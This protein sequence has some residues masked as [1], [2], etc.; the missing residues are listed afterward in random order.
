[1]PAR[2]RPEFFPSLPKQP[3]AAKRWML[4]AVLAA[5]LVVV[6]FALRRVHFEWGIFLTQLRHA[7]VLYLLLGVVCIYIGYL[8][9]A[10]R[11]S[12]FLRPQKPFPVTKLVGTQVI[13][14]TAVALFGRLADPVRPL[15]V[16]RRVGVTVSS[17]LAVYAMDRM[18]DALAM[19]L[20]FSSALALAPDARTLPHHELFQHA[21]YAGLAIAIAGG[22]FA[23]LIRVRGVQIA[24]VAA[25]VFGRISAGAGEAV[26]EKILAFRDG[27]RVLRSFGDFVQALAVSL[28][29]W[30][31]ILVAYFFTV[32]AF[33]ELRFFNLSRIMLLSAASLG[34][35]ALQLPV[36]GWFTQIGIVSAAMKGLGAPLE[37]AIG[38]AAMLLVVTFLSVIP[39]GLV[40]AKAEGVNLREVTRQS[41]AV[42]E[43]ALLG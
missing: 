25:R 37:P 30:A 33:A 15:L 9:R 5:L 16:S 27:M 29:M 34:G 32:H 6:A 18:F 3:A 13:G 14:F 38:A 8:C 11:W 41:E 28:L 23:V 24:A 39:A 4:W 19:A 1:M 2:W 35:S 7:N 12:I 40:F 43:A 17:Q 20:I 36:V 22:L 42:E 26:R 10:V 31:L 21:G